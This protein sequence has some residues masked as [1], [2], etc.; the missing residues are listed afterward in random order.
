MLFLVTFLL[1]C[2]LINVIFYRKGLKKGYLFG[3]NVGESNSKIVYIMDGYI[4]GY[5]D[6]LL[7]YEIEAD[8]FTEEDYDNRFYVSDDD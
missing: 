1:I 5:N 8:E 3:F 7:D 4:D 2:I 6:C